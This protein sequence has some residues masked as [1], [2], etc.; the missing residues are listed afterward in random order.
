MSGLGVASTDIVARADAVLGR[1][2]E[3][4]DL[5]AE[6]W[7][8]QEIAHSEG[9]HEACLAVFDRLCQAADGQGDAEI[10]TLARL[11]QADELGGMGRAA[12]AIRA[13]EE[14]LARAGAIAVAAK[15]AVGRGYALQGKAA[16]LASS[17]LDR[18]AIELL[19]RAATQWRLA[20]DPERL[21]EVLCSRSEALERMEL[22][23]TAEASW[24]ETARACEGAGNRPILARALNQVGL[25]AEAINRRHS[26][27]AA[28]QRAAS[29]YRSAEAPGYEAVALT[30]RARYLSRLGRR[31]EAA[32][33]HRA[34]AIS[35][36]A[37]EELESA[38]LAYN[39]SALVA[40][41][42]GDFDAALAAFAEA[43]KL[44][45]R[46][47]NSR[48]EAIVRSNRGSL[49]MRLERWE[50]ARIALETEVDLRRATIEA[51]GPE[52]AHAGEE[53][54]YVLSL[55]RLADVFC[56]LASEDEAATVPGERSSPRPAE[57]EADVV[58]AEFRL[59]LAARRAS[60]P[61]R[62]L[63]AFE[64][65]AARA[66]ELGLEEEERRILQEQDAVLHILCV[67]SDRE[68]NF[69]SMVRYARDLLVLARRR[70]DP[71]GESEALNLHGVAEHRERKYEEACVLFEQAIDVARR[72]AAAAQEERALV[73]LGAAVQ[74]L[75]RPAEAIEHYE[76][77]LVL[78]QPE[79]GAIRMECLGQ[80]ALSQREAGRPEDA[81]VSLRRKLALAVDRKDAAQEGSTR[82][83]IGM[84][85]AKVW[86]VDEAIRE[87][88]RARRIAIAIEDRRMEATA[89]N[90]VGQLLGEIGDEDRSRHFLTRATELAKDCGNESLD[91]LVMN[92]LASVVEDV[93]AR[94][95]QLE[96]VATRAR[97]LG[98]V[99]MQ[100]LTELN[101]GA[102]AHEMNR[103]RDAKRHYRR[104]IAHYEALGDEGNLTLTKTNLAMLGVRSA[105]TGS[106]KVPWYK[107]HRRREVRLDGG[108]RSVIW[109]THVMVRLIDWRGLRAAR[110]QHEH[111]LAELERSGNAPGVV[112]MLRNL[113]VLELH[114]G[115]YQ[116]AFALF[117]RC[118]EALER[119]RAEVLEAELR[120]AFFAVQQQLFD[121]VV[122]LLVF[123]GQGPRAFVAAERS[124]SRSLLDSFYSVP[125]GVSGG[126]ND[127]RL[128]QLQTELQTAERSWRATD[129]SDSAAR[130][131]EARIADIEWELRTIDSPTVSNTL[132][133]NAPATVEEIQEGLL[134][135]DTAL[136]EYRLS[137]HKG[138]LFC[139]T[140]RKFKTF[141]LPAAA[142][143]EGRVRELLAAVAGRLHRYP[144]GA[145]LYR[146]LIRPAERLLRRE[147]IRK[148]LVVADGS[149]NSLPFA[150]LL[151]ES[152]ERLN[153]I[154]PEMRYVGDALTNR[155]SEALPKE[156][157]SWVEMPY[158]LHRFAIGHA[159][160]GSI[161]LAQ[162]R[163]R[164]PAERDGATLIAF[165]DPVTPDRLEGT[166]E[167]ALAIT[168]MVAGSTLRPQGREI[169]WSDEE[170]GVFLRTGEHATKE[171]LLRLLGTGSFDFVHIATHGLLND[172]RPQFSG[173]ALS[174]DKERAA[175]P[176]LLGLDLRHA[177]I[178]AELVTL[179]ACETGL[180]KLVRGEGV[181]GLAHAFLSAGARSV[182]VSLW[183]VLDGSTPKLMEHFYKGLID[184]EERR[185]ALRDAQ[186]LMLDEE[187]FA[188][189]YHW[190]AFVMIGTDCE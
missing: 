138:I 37:G 10:V 131:F 148:L 12:S 16:V 111:R 175:N 1:G 153:V 77:A 121:M 106:Q 43:G 108:L 137:P 41:R 29:V 82:L 102:A 126:E 119:A 64:G 159:P 189:P 7:S 31:Q 45:R 117:D 26:A 79:A 165:A 133:R 134:D 177:E 87:Y 42:A 18:D 23:S 84:A 183:R 187:E 110:I 178:D 19:S 21:V 116:R 94:A 53:A 172:V 154:D 38:A 65:S 114:R 28:F 127:E 167:E 185:E 40:Q 141:A 91:L 13:Y 101:L 100:A 123:R 143:I 180:G 179:S 129:P 170:K 3:Y 25:C 5:M 190:A 184:G 50:E 152:R 6:L 144:H 88:Q 125:L 98:D 67:K 150:L 14:G 161:A 75:G 52:E 62:A 20:E 49:L 11:R 164:R 44:Y 140:K 147:S 149:L 66:R 58:G 63:R 89:I 68:R 163:L 32:R 2:L 169:E 57:N 188:H 70:N 162:R 80:L 56:H 156:P 97:E 173:L 93:E 174:P 78:R 146:V 181:I 109:A 47:E 27:L 95:A 34:A 130:E 113:A 151:T 24:N 30:N 124:R 135:E 15:R 182:C 4:T 157:F 132:P 60:E 73:N 39:E 103:R 171:E 96:L 51:A 33:D 142:E 139:V 83:Q 17:G 160:S 81:L 166:A 168:S 145:D 54:A 186:V 55:S 155:I 9:A 122:P 35:H 48:F 8:L 69:E 112:L 104:A 128:K 59:G 176:N 120:M 90:N 72:A 99:K 107:I 118:F 86:E 115:R 36:L 74:N 105:R 61:E 92:N 71:V 136:L 85:C 158:L 76:A 22:W 46:A